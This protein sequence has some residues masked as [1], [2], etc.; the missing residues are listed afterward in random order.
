MQKVFGKRAVDFAESA[1]SEEINGDGD[2]ARFV[3][4][5]DDL[6]VCVVGG[7]NAE[8]QK[9]GGALQRV[10]AVSVVCG[11]EQLEIGRVNVGSLQAGC[12]GV[13]IAAAIFVVGRSALR[14]PEQ[15]VSA[16]NHTLRRLRT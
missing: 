8:F 12:G 7:L 4:E 5:G 15:A 10:A 2:F 3:E 13:R 6:V 1:R 9:A 14:T 11:P 16:L